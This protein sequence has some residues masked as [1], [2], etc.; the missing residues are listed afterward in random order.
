[1]AGKEP[2]FPPGCFRTLGGG[3]RNW[4]I[5]ANRVPSEWFPDWFHSH[6]TLKTT[7]VCSDPRASP[8][9]DLNAL[10]DGRGDERLVGKI[11]HGF[12]EWP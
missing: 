10:P 3:A 11:C 12:F 6:S 8:S 4:K 5:R 9:A 2:Q 1:M 7:L